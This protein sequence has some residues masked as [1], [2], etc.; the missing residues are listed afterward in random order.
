MQGAMGG[1][2]RRDVPRSTSSARPTRSA[3]SD[4][5]VLEAPVDPP[6]VQE[7]GKGAA[8]PKS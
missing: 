6:Q 5:P 4:A 8:Q 2:N 3:P 7:K 1:G